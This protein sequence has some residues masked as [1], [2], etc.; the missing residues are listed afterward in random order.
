MH[1]VTCQHLWLS[2]RQSGGQSI[3]GVGGLRKAEEGWDLGGQRWGGK[4]MLAI[5]GLEGALDL[6]LPM[7]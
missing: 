1:T 4:D 5:E 3:R 6:M 2:A 7:Q